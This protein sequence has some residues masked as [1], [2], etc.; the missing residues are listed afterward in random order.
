MAMA[1]TYRAVSDYGKAVFGEEPFD[2]EFTASDEGDHLGS[3][4]LEIV[5]RTYRQLS[6]NYSA[7]KQGATF[8][9]AFVVDHESAL[10]QGGHIKRA[11]A[12]TT[13]KRKG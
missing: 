5:P 13:P 8:L 1:N 9:G 4:H 10:I 3:G 12:P 2:H 6:N 7:A 11:D